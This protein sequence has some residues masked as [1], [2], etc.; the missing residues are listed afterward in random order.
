[1]TEMTGVGDNLKILN[2]EGITP[3]RESI[4]GGSYPLADGYYAVV[5]SDLPE[6]HSARAVISWLK[7]EDG[8]VYCYIQH[9][10]YM[11]A[12]WSI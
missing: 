3:D 1:M 11:E 7:S 10:F 6:E 5:R 2:Y 9:L 12:L 4:A 8:V